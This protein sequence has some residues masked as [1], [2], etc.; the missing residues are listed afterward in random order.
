[1]SENQLNI[2]SSVILKEIL[3]QSPVK[4]EME[5]SAE[6]G[7]DYDLNTIYIMASGCDDD[8][9]RLTPFVDPCGDSAPSQNDN[10][11]IYALELR[12]ARGDSRGG[13]ETTNANLGMLYGFLQS[14]LN[15]AGFNVI[16]HCDE[17]F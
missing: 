17:I 16:D 14:K 3:D 8:I 11:P 2:W 6:R 10:V 1:M 12:N 7:G 5:V 4:C 15:E 9:L 13:C